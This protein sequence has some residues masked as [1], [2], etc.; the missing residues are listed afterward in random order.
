MQEC[1]DTVEVEVETHAKSLSYKFQLEDD[2]HSFDP[3]EVQ[4]SRF[5]KMVL[6]LN[7][8][9]EERIAFKDEFE[10]ASCKIKY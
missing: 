9:G 6:L 7:K 1:S 3:A 5:E 10:K 8:A 2:A 4:L